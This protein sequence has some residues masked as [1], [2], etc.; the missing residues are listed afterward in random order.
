MDTTTLRLALHKTRRKLTFWRIVAI[1]AIAVLAIWLLGRS[2][3]TGPMQQE[4]IA[5]VRID[6]FIL[7]QQKKIDL[8]DKL[9]EDRNVRAVIVRINSPGGST[10]G[11]QAI[12]DA[13]KRLGKKKPVVTVMDSVAAS[14]GYLVALAGERMFASGN[15]ITGSIGVIVQWPELQGL[16]G[17]LGVRMESVRS[18][19]LKALPNSMEPTP[20]E[21]KEAIAAMVRD[22][23]DWFVGLV[24]ARRGLDAA[25]ARKL[26]DGRIYTG[27]QALKARL[28]DALGDERAA[29]AWLVEKHK[30]SGK[31]KVVEHRPPKPLLQQ[32]GLPG[33]L[34][35]L[36]LHGLGLD[37]AWEATTG[38]ALGASGRV[39]GLLSVWHP[40]LMAARGNARF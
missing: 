10:A 8:I 24:A 18:G 2:G 27:R 36:A 28:V 31:L 26:A 6:G 11:S 17:K 35:A 33:T 25:T 13:L 20:P 16:L 34:A 9:A 1:A 39:D 40:R 7:G 30:I 29:K 38:A 22:S 4:H 37:V 15:T 23:H 19:P 12:H 3:A 14:G 5:R 21:A 32:L